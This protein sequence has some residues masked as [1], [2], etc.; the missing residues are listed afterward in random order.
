M[1]ITERA[2]MRDLEIM[3]SITQLAG[4]NLID[5]IRKF[6]VPTKVGRYNVQKSDKL[7]IVQM[8]M[9]WDMK[10]GDQL[11]EYTAAFFLGVPKK[12]ISSL[13]L[14][15]FV[16]LTLYAKEVADEAKEKFE[17]IKIHHKDS[18]V[19]MI[20]ENSQSPAIS[21]ID[22]FAERN[23]LK[24]RLSSDV[25]RIER[26]LGINKAA[27]AYTWADYFN[28]FKLDYI[29]ADIQNKISDLK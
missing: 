2:K 17:S 28:Y 16:R 25:S 26:I 11:S 18:R 10:S 14:I 23:G 22:R 1:R 15:D 27:D 24:Y 6:G 8:M 7:T 19:Q 3:H 4:K 21:I 5:E 9:L 29:N 12:T 13:P 20:I